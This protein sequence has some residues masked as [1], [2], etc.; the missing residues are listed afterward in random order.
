[1]PHPAV[2]AAI[3]VGGVAALGLAIYK[4]LQEQE[5]YYHYQQ[6]S[7]NSR[8]QHR[9][10]FRHSNDFELDQD[11]MAEEDDKEDNPHHLH[12]DT[13]QLRSR[14]PYS[15][16]FSDHEDE[17]TSHNE[18]KTATSS[19]D[20]DQFELA[21]LES[22][23]AE[24][25]RR[26]MAE[27]AF[28]DR[29]EE[30]LRNRRLELQREE[31]GFY[32]AAASSPN[33]ETE[34]GVS[35]VEVLDPFATHFAYSGN[36][37]SDDDSYYQHGHGNASSSGEHTAILI[38]SKREES[39]SSGAHESDHSN[40]MHSSNLQFPDASEV[41]VTDSEAG[42][43]VSSSRAV[44]DSEESWDAV[45]ENEWARHSDNEFEH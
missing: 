3:V 31:Q 35:A 14:K 45:S 44:S 10:V 22:S 12:H 24:R 6:Q 42:T 5:N 39:E 30:N 9:N 1:M 43:S 13:T 37:D 20:Q 33:E 29:E 4:Q 25:K 7:Y 26:L 28:L 17:A 18:K 2:L 36:D 34:S 38:N 41:I 11:F 32:Q 21:E 27:Q 15:K 8:Q 23:I 16:G 19:L 40:H